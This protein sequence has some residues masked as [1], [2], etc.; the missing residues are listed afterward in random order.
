MKRIAIF[1]I[2]YNSYN[3]LRR[4]LISLDV[5]A[6]HA[7]SCFD[8]DVYVIDNTETDFEEI[9]YLTSFKNIT[10]LLYPHHKNLGYFGGARSVMST[11]DLS[12]YEYVAVTNVDLVASEDLFANLSKAELG[13]G[14]GWIAISIQ[15]EKEGRDR[16][17]SVLKRY[18]ERKLKLLKFKF[19]VPIVDHVYNNTLYKRKRIGKK[20]PQMDIY[21]GHGSFILLTR[22]YF[23]KCGMIEYPVFL[24]GEELYLAE[25]CREHSLRVV[26]CP[27]VVVYDSEHVSTNKMSRAISFKQTFYYK[28]NEAAINF[29]LKNYY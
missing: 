20:Y 4:Y 6:G 5:A 14:V 15:S 21:A 23:Q 1:C 8:V 28:C 11:V 18:S 13:D 10:C 27:S 7:K 2:T 12:G 19:K 22:E 17:P 25:Q 26:Y 9:D 24:F 16:N 29:I 3:E